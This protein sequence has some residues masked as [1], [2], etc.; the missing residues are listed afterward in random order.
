MFPGAVLS[1]GALRD[2][3]W[4][5]KSYV[6]D[7]DFAIPNDA[8]DGYHDTTPLTR[9]WELEQV[10][11]G[12]YF[13]FRQEVL[14]V[15]RYVVPGGLPNVELIFL[16]RPAEG[17]AKYVTNRNDFG[18]CQVAYSRTPPG[19]SLTM[20]DVEGWFTASDAFM[21][22]EHLN[23]FTLVNC[24][25]ETQALRSIR[26]AERW[27]AKYPDIEMDLTKAWDMLPTNVIS[28]FPIQEAVY[29]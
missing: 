19:L 10:F 21:L 12:H 8:W 11:N 23:K 4:D 26:R 2:L 13:G 22:D 5:K 27:R 28:P 7:L 6:K 25:D 1:G 17:L 24:E 29:A 3:V 20:R 14:S 18:C 9:D 16:D 15:E